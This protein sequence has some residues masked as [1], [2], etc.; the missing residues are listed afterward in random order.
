MIGTGAIVGS[1]EILERLGTGG[2]GEVYRARHLHLDRQAAIKMLLMELSQDR[3]AVDRFFAEARATSLIHH[4]GIVEILDCNVHESGRVY[5]VMEL[6]EGETLANRLRRDPEL[7]RNLP[8]VLGIADQIADALGAAHARG[9]VHRDLKPENVFLVDPP[10]SQEGGTPRVKVLDFGI[11]KLLNS[12]GGAGRDSQVHTQADRVLG[13]P[14]YMSPE[15]CRDARFVDHRTDI[16]SLGCVLFEMIAGHVP[17]EA[18]TFGQLVAAQLWEPPPPL[19][20]PAARLVGRMLA[21]DPSARLQTMKDVRSEIAT[22]MRRVRAGGRGR[23]LAALGRRWESFWDGRIASR[24]PALAR[25]IAQPLGRWLGSLVASR[26]RMVGLGV[27]W[28]VVVSVV[29]VLALRE[30][31]APAQQ[32]GAAT[33]TPVV[34]AAVGISSARRAHVQL[35]PRGTSAAVDHRGSPDPRAPL[36]AGTEEVTQKATQE[37]TGAPTEEPTEGATDEGKKAG[38]AS[39]SRAAALVAAEP[40]AAVDADEPLPP[41]TPI[42]RIAPRP[43][44]AKG[45]NARA[46]GTHAPHATS[47]PPDKVELT[48]DQRKL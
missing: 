23:D 16:Y 39:P 36:P 15:Q 43:R 6:L 45:T 48:D 21:K 41:T 37:A 28:V 4:P 40:E 14:A 29:A 44:A 13:T 20:P 3:E 1:Y 34:G 9:I 2:M 38:K 18:S 5:L 47:S 30:R 11:A 31:G 17:F 27:G 22:V 26:R 24:L 19:P 33:S 32:S 8:L 46:V 25:P 7:G 42:A 35:T 12:R 10:A